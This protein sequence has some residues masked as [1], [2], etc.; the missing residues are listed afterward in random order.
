MKNT[1]RFLFHLKKPD[2]V[3]NVKL[4]HHENK[5]HC[6]H[7]YHYPAYG[8]ADAKYRRSLFQFSLGRVPDVQTGGASFYSDYFV[9]TWRTGWPAKTG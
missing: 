5:N 7:P 9:C 6:H 3:L 4:N 1:E 8:C 2:I